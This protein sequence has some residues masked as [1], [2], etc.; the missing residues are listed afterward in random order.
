MALELRGRCQQPDVA[1]NKN[2][3]TPKDPSESSDP[4]QLTPS[5]SA[6]LQS[7]VGT[8]ISRQEKRDAKDHREAA[9]KITL[10]NGYCYC[11]TDEPTMAGLATSIMEE[12][13]REHVGAAQPASR[14]RYLATLLTRGSS[15][16]GSLDPGLGQS[17]STTVPRRGQ[18]ARFAYTSTSS[19]HSPAGEVKDSTN[20]HS[21]CGM[22]V[23]S[24]RAAIV[25]G[26][27]KYAD[28]RAWL[29]F[30]PLDIPEV[31]RRNKRQSAHP[32]RCNGRS[33]DIP[34]RRPLWSA[35]RLCRPYIRLPSRFGTTSSL[36]CHRFW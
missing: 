8:G 21:R 5:V 29:V 24:F 3:D 20:Y 14:Q 15:T 2:Q 35:R 16:S 4:Y 36:F 28:K 6:Q 19:V 30:H 18:H 10:A 22:R 17:R 13:R 32:S 12:R 34:H 26:S 1:L 33:S 31:G 27:F 7:T 9:E 25:L 11:L 23:G